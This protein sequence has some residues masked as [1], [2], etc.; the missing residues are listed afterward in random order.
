MKAVTTRITKALPVGAIIS[1]ADNTG[2]KELQIIS[3]RGFKAHRK[4]LPAAGVADLVTCRV[5]RG[6][7]KVRHEVMKAVIIRQKKPWRRLN[8]MR[9][10]FE[11]N[12]AV[13]V[14][15][16]FTPKGTMIK[17]PVAKEVV[18]RFPAIGKLASMIV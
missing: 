18:E 5:Y 13:I 15:D 11:D 14:D 8:G 3:V 17:G 9:I 6:I 7:E 16:K 10:S 2:A 4:L 12:A 1:C